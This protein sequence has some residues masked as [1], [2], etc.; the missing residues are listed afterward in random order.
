[1]SA[2]FTKNSL[3]KQGLKQ[4]RF[5][6][7]PLKGAMGIGMTPF[8]SSQVLKSYVHIPFTGNYKL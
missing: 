5:F 7:E 3:H 4:F 8:E 1:M 6:Q 2:F